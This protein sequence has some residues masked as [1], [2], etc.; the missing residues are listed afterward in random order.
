MSTR[1]RARKSI[2]HLF[3]KATGLGYFPELTQDVNGK[4][5]IQVPNGMLNPSSGKS[6]IE[7]LQDSEGDD[8][9]RQTTEV[10][11]LGIKE[12]PPASPAPLT[13][14]TLTPIP[15]KEFVE[16]TQPQLLVSESDPTLA[17]HIPHRPSSQSNSTFAE[18]TSVPLAEFVSSNCPHIA[19]SFF[20]KPLILPSWSIQEAAGYSGWFTKK[21]K[22]DLEWERYLTTTFRWR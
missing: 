9:E 7:S 18:I 22:N 14:T 20:I 8:F 10:A 1:P 12:K 2:S 6:I 15:E 4:A 21:I 17:L 11:E 5:T 13:P 16:D 3:L 19:R